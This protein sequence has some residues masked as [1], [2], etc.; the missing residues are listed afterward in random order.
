[1]NTSCAAPKFSTNNTNY[2]KLNLN[3]SADFIIIKDKRKEVSFG[4]DI[5]IPVISHQN[6][7]EVF[8]PPLNEEHEKILKQTVLEN[9]DSSSIRSSIITIQ[10]LQ[11]RKEFYAKNFAENEGSVVEIKV[12][13]QINGQEYEAQ[14]MGEYTMKSIDATYKR[15]ERIYQNALKEVTYN[16]LAELRNKIS[17]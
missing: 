3:F 12:T 8:Y 11:G 13:S 5:H 6:Q 1:M 10:V 14:A 17:G 9:T 2:K 4:K 16:A 15:S 7:N